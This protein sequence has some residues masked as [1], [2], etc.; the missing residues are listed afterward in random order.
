MHAVEL[1]IASHAKLPPPSIFSLLLPRLPPL[2]STAPRL[3]MEERVTLPTDTNN[4]N[5]HEEIVQIKPETAFRPGTYVVQVPKDQIYR[6]PPPENA[7]IAERH[8]SNHQ[9]NKID[10]RGCCSR[11]LIWL[12][13]FV[14]LVV[15]LGLIAWIVFMYFI[16]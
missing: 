14:I 6:V 12:L 4:P 2:L 9:G 3:P 16:N 7:L 5:P 1:L 8:R 13:S 15:V 11:R 10:N